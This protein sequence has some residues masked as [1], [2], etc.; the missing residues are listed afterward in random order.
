VPN[1]QTPLMYPGGVLILATSRSTTVPPAAGGRG[2][3]RSE[4]LS[5]WGRPA[6]IIQ[7]V[8]LAVLKLRFQ[9]SPALALLRSPYAPEIAVFLDGA[10]K[11]EYRLAIPGDDLAA[12][13]QAF[14]ETEVHPQS[15]L[16]FPKPPREY[17]E[18]WC[19]DEVGWLRRYYDRDEAVFELSADAERVLQWLE[20]LE[21]RQVVG[22]ESRFRTVF[23]LLEEILEFSS[24]DI[25]K[26]VQE[27]ERRRDEIAAKIQEIL[28][29]GSV[30]TLSAG[31]V[32][33]RF[34]E[35]VRN[36]RSL[37]GDFRA[38]EQNFRLITQQLQER[39]LAQGS[40]RGDMVGFVLQ[41]DRALEDSEQGQSFY[42]FLRFLLSEPGR[43]EFDKLLAQVEELPALREQL[44]ANPALRQLLPRLV[45]E[46][47]K[48]V[49]T[50]HRLSEQLRR[51]LDRQN[52]QE[53]RRVFDVIQEIKAL[54]QQLR[55]RLD[56]ATPVIELPLKPGLNAPMERPLW[57]PR[58]E[59]KMRSHI[60]DHVE[61]PYAA[62]GAFDLL[63][64]DVAQLGRQVEQILRDQEQVTLTEL[65]Q[66][67]PPEL[68][69]F[70]LLGYLSLATKSSRH[71][72]DDQALMR[73]TIPP[74]DDRRAQMVEFPQIYFTR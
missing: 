27:L 46:S 22:T 29:R 43:A 55:G 72:I 25:E 16:A 44:P 67:F 41:R 52:L 4:I 2:R 17:L 70:D 63:A 65:L 57:R 30:E 7:T 35:A 66:R 34:E 6:G 19:H 5:S 9:E 3:S 13:L 23:R 40:T 60:D 38:V 36:A 33:E 58:A 14:L 32:Q 21:P 71:R 18:E 1:L 61:R 59:I 54:A 51:A 24:G 64:L 11:S 12:M 28:A 48:V 37:L 31:Q 68:G 8:E 15:P 74:K 20:D 39:Q 10:F 50:N 56:P 62:L 49:R 73:F 53:R 47:G 26:R 69:V 42:A 45:A